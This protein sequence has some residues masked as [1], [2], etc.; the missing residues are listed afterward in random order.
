VTA[1]ARA[2]LLARGGGPAPALVCPLVVT[3]AAAIEALT[4]EE[5]LADPTKL[6]KGLALLRDAVDGDVIVTADGDPR[7]LT[8]DRQAE[9]AVEA[10][11]RLVETEIDAALAVAL[12]GPARF[13]DVE[14]LRLARRFL[15]AGAHLLLFVEDRP[16]GDGEAWRAALT[17]VVNVV[18]FHQA[19]A[20]AVLAGGESDAGHAPRG[21]VVCVPQPRL[22][23]GL[24]LAPDPPVWATPAVDVPLITTLGPMTGDFSAVTAAIK[25]LK[26]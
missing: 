7:L 2:R 6:A 1:R 19:A 23:Q 14:L 26:P 13:P 11:R 25:D 22:G 8:D 10:T 4:V 20:V 15:D 18:R 24:A 12:P 17:P 16:L 9:A 3:P 5:F 21:T